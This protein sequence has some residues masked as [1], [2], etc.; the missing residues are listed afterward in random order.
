MRSGRRYG[1]ISMPK[2]WI[3]TQVAIIVF[4]CIGIVIAIT[5]LV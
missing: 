2:M 3:Y 1:C 4:V 5:K